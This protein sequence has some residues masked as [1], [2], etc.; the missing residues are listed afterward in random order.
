MPPY[1]RDGTWYSDFR[2]IDPATG[3]KRRFRQPLGPHL[4]SVKD[5][6]RA[7]R[8]LQV[9]I[10]SRTP[11]TGTPS[12]SES[13]L[14]DSRVKRAAFSGLAARWLAVAIAPPKC[15][16]K[17]YG[18]YESLCRVWLVPFFG[19]RQ[20][21]TITPGDVEALQRHMATTTR[22]KGREEPPGPKSINEAVGCLSSMLSWAK[23][24]GFLRDNPCERVERLKVPEAALEFY[25]ATETA[26]WLT[27]CRQVAPKWYSFFLAGFRTGLR[28]GEL[29]ALRVEDLALGRRQLHVRRT[30]GCA[31]APRAGDEPLLQVW[32]EVTPKSSRSRIVGLSPGLVEVLAEHIGTRHAGLVWSVPP[33]EEDGD[34]H[35]RPASVL[36]GW[37][38]ATLSA[39]LPLYSLHSMRHSFASQLV[40]AGVPL[41]HVQSLLGHSTIKMTEKYAHLA[42]GFASGHVGVLDTELVTPG[43]HTLDKAGARPDKMVGA[44]GFEPV[45]DVLDFEAV[46]RKKRA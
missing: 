41:A 37:E 45:A 16:P 7:E 10:E 3:Q 4:R 15:K 24:E 32:S 19:D 36:Y 33:R 39:K 2:A 8:A 23:R 43:G 11:A 14:A 35:L 18:S 27:A 22:A 17:T 38:K 13:A 21:S 30:Y 29:F 42:P 31:T 5:A 44:T 46:E 28:E 40:M 34:A 26:R 12:R 20:V 25:D 1:N 9:E 6:E